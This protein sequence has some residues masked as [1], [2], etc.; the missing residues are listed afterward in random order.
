ML[1]LTN[2]HAVYIEHA[3]RFTVV[4]CAAK[5]LLSAHPIKRRVATAVSYLHVGTVLQY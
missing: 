3:S 2:H 5:K 4:S 1:S